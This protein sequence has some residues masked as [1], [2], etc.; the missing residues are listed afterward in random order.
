MDGGARFDPPHPLAWAKTK[1]IKAWK[2]CKRSVLDARISVELYVTG[3][4][5]IP[6]MTLPVFGMWIVRIFL[7][8]LMVAICYAA[9]SVVVGMF[10]SHATRGIADAVLGADFAVALSPEPSVVISIPGE[11]LQWDSPTLSNIRVQT[12]TKNV[13]AHTVLAKDVRAG[14]GRV[15]LEDGRSL[16]WNLTQL[17]QLHDEIA[18]DAPV[19]SGNSCLCGIH[20]GVCAGSAMSLVNPLLP[21]GGRCIHTVNARLVDADIPSGTRVVQERNPM[22]PDRVQK[23]SR[24]ISISLEYMDPTPPHEKKE[25]SVTGHAAFCVQ[26]CME[27]NEGKSPFL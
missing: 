18:N 26:S 12:K 11:E 6:R 14:L 15:K 22:F 2:K 13:C 27:L 17:F 21:R 10:K 7:A 1:A 3:P 4:R 25:M 16:A 24:V 23:T 19:D 5:W 8:V 9:M 20:R